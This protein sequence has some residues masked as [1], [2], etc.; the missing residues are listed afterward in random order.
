MAQSLVKIWVHVS[1]ATKK[2]APLINRKWERDLYN[3][4]TVKLTEQKC[5]VRIVNGMPD[6]V[7][8]LFMLPSTKCIADVMSYVKGESSRWSNVNY[9]E[10]QNE[11]FEWQDGYG[12]FSIS[13][14]NV[15]KVQSYI[16]NQK[17]IHQ[18]RTFKEEWDLLKKDYSD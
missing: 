14:K 6:H 2:R 13:E 10:T 11:N 1:F 7:H 18:N 9:F 8:L 16:Y 12:A 17:A 5:K 15:K 4:M 3:H